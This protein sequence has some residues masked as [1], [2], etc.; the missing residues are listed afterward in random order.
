MTEDAS[1]AEGDARV[2]WFEDLVLRSLKRQWPDAIL[3]DLARQIAFVND[4]LREFLEWR[5]SFSREPLVIT[6][7]RTAV[8]TAAVNP[9]TVKISAKRRPP[10]QLAVLVLLWLIL[11]VGPVAAEKLPDEIQVMLSTE[12]GTIAL[13]LAITQ[14]MNDKRK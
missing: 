5:G 7:A 2:T 8:A 13:G 3:P 9:A 4:D 14:M 11:L 6:F 10:V 1:A 12:V